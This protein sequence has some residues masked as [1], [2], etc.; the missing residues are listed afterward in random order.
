MKRTLAQIIA[1]H[2]GQPLEK[3][4]EDSDRDYFMSAEDAVKY[5]LIDKGV[6]PTKGKKDT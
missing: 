4:I 1:E 6:T 2:T 5:G 3:V